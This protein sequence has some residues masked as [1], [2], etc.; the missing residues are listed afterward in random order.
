[1]RQVRRNSRRILPQFEYEGNGMQ[2]LAFSD[3][4]G[5]ASTLKLL[6]ENTRREEFDCIL[7]AGDLTNAD[8]VSTKETIRQVNE[9]FSIMESFKIPYYYVWGLPNRERNL[10]SLIDV[11]ENPSDY[12]VGEGSV[13]RLHGG[14]EEEAL[15]FSREFLEKDRLESF[16]FVPKNDWEAL[17]RTVRFLDS[18]KFG[19]LVKED[20]IKLGKY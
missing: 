9:V 11:V 14:Q 5:D 1:M 16:T 2:V 3:L 19:R 12:K 17:N 20:P 6:R 10:A 13:R 18:L 7:V 15:V 8:L 4:H